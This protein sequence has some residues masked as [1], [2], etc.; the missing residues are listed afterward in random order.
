MTNSNKNKKTELTTYLGKNC[1][2]LREL[3][4]I[5]REEMAIHTG[6]TLANIYKFERGENNNMILFY[7]YCLLVNGGDLI[8]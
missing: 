8:D 2:L 5:S 3:R 7:L 6:Y 1:R 4:G